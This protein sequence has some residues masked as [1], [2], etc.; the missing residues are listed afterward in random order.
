M[1]RR[2]VL[3]YVGLAL[4]I[5]VL[6][7]VPFGLLAQRHERDMAA[8]QAEREATALA[9]VA[10]EDVEHQRTAE[11]NNLLARYQAR[12]GGELEIVN[13]A[14]HVLASSRGDGDNDAT[15]EA[16]NLVQAAISGRS[17][18]SFSSDEGSPWATAAVPITADN[19]PATAVLL[20]IPAT[21]TENRI[22]GIW[23]ALGG[24]AVATLAVTA[25]VGLLL[26]R[27]LA[28]PLARLEST[29]RMLGEGDLSVRAGDEGPPQ[30]RS[31][32]R[33]FNHMAGRL[34]DL[35]EAQ[36]RFLADASHQLRSPLTALRLRLENLEAS[37]ET[38]SAEGIAAAAEEVQRLSRIVDGLLTL[39]R[40]GSDEPDRRLVDVEAVIEGRCEA[41]SALAA[42]RQVDL[43]PDVQ[44]NPCSAALLVP[45]DLE[46]I[47]DNLLANA[48]DVSPEGGQI[49]VRLNPSDD[50]GLELHVTD[51]GPG[52]SPDDRRR[53]FDRFWQGAGSDGGH[54]GLGLAIVRQLADRNQAGAELHQSSP[55]GID[56]VI[57]LT[58]AGN[59]P[60]QGA[61][62][63]E[64][65]K[66]S[67]DSRAGPR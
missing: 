3:S 58:S 65:V 53:A 16:R 7:E 12:T 47:L 46:Q 1:T 2:L 62:G 29:V 14:S 49:S 41:W 39:S 48:L 34:A 17:V 5:L 20:G 13:P 50:N 11:L 38:G 27:S 56:A 43:T 66:K 4:L 24:F 45:G 55:S 64:T 9:A 57:T 61:V 21:S 26:A 51:E 8:S 59:R 67:R 33:Q 31:L 42:E 28:R 37:T 19:Q 35:M 36:N 52:M 60:R 30:V 44:T 54:S 63:S 6:L 10:S 23:L 22:E 18:S 32:A 25:V 40:V 15:G